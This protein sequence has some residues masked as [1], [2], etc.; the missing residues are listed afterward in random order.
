LPFA[1]EPL[2]TFFFAGAALVF[3]FS[4]IVVSYYGR[5]PR[6]AR[7]LEPVEYYFGVIS[8]PKSR[9]FRGRPSRLQFRFSPNSRRARSQ[10]C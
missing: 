3:R 1:G 10:R 4:G 2:V 5:G 7:E 9:S 8:S 6:K